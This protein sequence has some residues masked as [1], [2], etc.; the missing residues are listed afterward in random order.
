MELGAGSMELGAESGLRGSRARG[1]CV[2]APEGRR[3][4]DQEAKRRR[5]KRYKGGK[6]E[7]ERGEG[8]RPCQNMGNTLGSIHR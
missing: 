4:K 1:L 7:R 6:V 5:G 8:Q 2:I 3:P